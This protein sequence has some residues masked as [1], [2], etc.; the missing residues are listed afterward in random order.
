M[1]TD[2]G[3]FGTG[4]LV[5]VKG[6]IDAKDEDNGRAIYGSILGLVSRKDIKYLNVIFSRDESLKALAWHDLLPVFRDKYQKSERDEGILHY[7]EALSEY[8]QH[9]D[10]LTVVAKNYN[11]KQA[12]QAISRYCLDRLR[13]KAV[14]LIECFNATAEDIEFFEEENK[15]SADLLS[16]RK[17]QEEPEPEEEIAESVQDAKNSE[18][19]LEKIVIRCEPVLDPV[20]GIA[21]NELNI[22]KLVMVK[23]PFDSILFKLLSNNIVNFDGIVTAMVNGIFLNELGTSSINLSLSDGVTGMMKVPGKVRVKMAQNQE[24]SRK[25]TTSIHDLSANFLFGAVGVAIFILALAV[26][27]YILR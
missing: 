18:E 7:E 10:A 16:A 25:N 21:A 22:G 11:I 24:S 9:G 17:G 12:E 26:V 3:P 8:L 20:R 1:D 15:L 23:L 27:Y 6:Y 2:L 19:T 4:V 13:L 5:I 14:S